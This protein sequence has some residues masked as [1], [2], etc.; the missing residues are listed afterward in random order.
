[1]ENN[2]PIGKAK[3]TKGIVDHFRVLGLEKGPRGLVRRSDD[4]GV[5]IG[6]SKVGASYPVPKYILM[7]L[8]L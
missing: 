4:E 6:R 5:A 2:K 3:F 1:L 7:D 8:V